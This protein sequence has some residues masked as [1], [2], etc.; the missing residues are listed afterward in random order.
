MEKQAKQIYDTTIIKKL[1]TYIRKVLESFPAKKSM[2]VNHMVQSFPHKDKPIVTLLIYQR[3]IL[4]LAELLDGR[5]SLSIQDKIYRTIIDNMANLD[6]E[7]KIRNRKGTHL[8]KTFPTHDKKVAMN[9]IFQKIE[10]REQYLVKMM[11][12][13]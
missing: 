5:G 12:R 7:I 1:P 10:S 13:N 11:L 8:V 4:K 9:N 6:V 3:F 2:I